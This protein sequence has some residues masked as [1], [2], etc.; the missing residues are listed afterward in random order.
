MSVSIPGGCRD[1]R[2]A[3][4]PPHQTPPET[5]RKVW[6]AVSPSTCALTS[7]FFKGKAK[8]ARLGFSG[9]SR[10]AFQALRELMLCLPGAGPQRKTPFS[11]SDHCSLRP[12][13]IPPHRIPHRFTGRRS[14]WN[15]HGRRKFQ[16]KYRYCLQNRSIN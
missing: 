9:E 7:W 1:G 3:T 8:R 14:P 13:C 5:A 16:I 2:G 12:L 11:P 4:S 10:N 15:W 6:Q